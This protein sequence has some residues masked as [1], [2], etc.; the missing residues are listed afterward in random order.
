[1]KEIAHDRKEV[2]VRRCIRVALVVVAGLAIVPS[3]AYAQASIA[4][5]VKDTSG[6]VLPGVTVEAASPVLIEKTRSVVTDNTGQYRIENLRPGSYTLTFSLTGFNTVKREGIEM[7]GS[8]TATINAELRVGALEETITVTGETP[9]VDVQNTTRQRVL[10]QELIDAIPSSRTPA[11][12]VALV[13]GVSVATQDVGGTRGIGPATVGDV[14]VHGSRKQDT[15]TMVNG[16]SLHNMNGGGEHG[17]PNLAAY[18]EVAFN[19]GSISSAEQKEGGVL[20]N[21][22]PRDGGNAYSGSFFGNFGNKSMQGDNFTQDLKDRGLGTPDSVKKTWDLNPAYGGPIRRD[23]VW[24]FSTLRYYG[25][26]SYVNMFFNKN[27]GNPN[28]WTYVPDTSRGPAWTEQVWRD[29]NARI[30]WQ[31]TPRN[32]V[33]ISH[34]RHA[35][36]QCPRALSAELA[37]EAAS[38]ARLNP[39]YMWAGDWTAPVTNRLLFDAAFVQ[40]GDRGGRA[41]ENFVTTSSGTLVKLNPVLEQTNNLTFRGKGNETNSWHTQIFYRTSVSYITGA[42]HLKVGFNNGKGYQD[43]QIYSVDDEMNFRFNN[44]VPNR[45][46]MRAVPYRTRADMDADLGLFVQ[47]TWTRHRLTL[48]TGLRYDYFKT[49]FPEQTIGPAKYVPTRNIVLAPTDGVKGFHDVQP[50]SGLAFDVF[51]DGKTALKLSV[52]R[53]VRGQALDGTFGDELN[54][55]NRLVVSTNRS[56][57][58]NFFPAGDARR[59]NFVP[60]CDLTNPAGNAEC[61]AMSDPNFG[62]TRP[63]TTYDPA[64]LSGWNTRDTNWEFAAGVQRELV[65]RV[66]MDVSYFRRW[67]S[68]F[69]VTDDRA[70]GASDYDVFSITA[71]VDPRLPGGGGYV[72][73]GLYDLKP[74]AF[75]RAADNYLTFADNYGK[76]TERWN[77]VDVS[78]NARPR[79]GVLMG[80]S[81]SSGRR[82]TDRCDVQ[83]AV[84]ESILNVT[85]SAPNI[86]YCLIQEA[87]RTQLKFLGTFT[88]PRVDVLVSGTFQSIPGPEVAA[89]YTV[90]NAV[91]AQSLGR[92][93]AGGASNVTV[94]LIAPGTMYGERMNQLDF[95]VG[96]I[97]R[98]GRTRATISLDLY[99][100]LN[101]SPVLLE[102]TAFATWRTPQQILPARFAKVGVQFNF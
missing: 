17:V 25:T 60:D 31:V 78:V 58:D 98:V 20:M 30:T 83:A 87:F 51:G 41:P 73:S 48:T 99:N 40:K 38:Q 2:T 29:A 74:G 19:T 93:L 59:G 61:G 37:P 11:Y 47:D 50:R 34:D 85:A 32:K 3:A 15:R 13:A 22:I 55:A 27:A 26:S 100:A 57:N 67:F 75:G 6:A 4:G 23:K 12:M 24:F 62:G 5:L 7:T 102:S 8:F 35:A 86:P 90:P 54:P 44:G 84:P 45:L 14:T 9:I 92:S 94:N 76:Q 66:S 97:F 96:K 53:Y 80:G 28:A 21:L 77:G 79:A 69:I 63:A 43:Q 89:L 10:N 95:R 64:T 1:V 33:A 18:Q 70:V 65:P 52:N 49:S 101:A 81:V 39:R 82:T 42:H 91:A 88:V 36:C 46:T 68:N 72:V 16:V 56:W 71:P